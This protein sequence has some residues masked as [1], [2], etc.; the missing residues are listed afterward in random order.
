MGLYVALRTGRGGG[1]PPQPPLSPPPGPGKWGLDAAASAAPGARLALSCLPSSGG[2]R[3]ELGERGPRSWGTARRGS[4]G[5]DARRT[6]QAREEPGNVTGRCGGRRVRAAL[7]GISPTSNTKKLRLIAP[8]PPPPGERDGRLLPLPPV[9]AV[10]G[11]GSVTMFLQLPNSLLS[12][13]AHST[14]AG[15]PGESSCS[16]IK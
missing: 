14:S 1:A 7:W 12:P 11:C 16:P 10:R 3:A 2:A 15:L 13:H 8:C 4:D 5:R 9:G 6:A